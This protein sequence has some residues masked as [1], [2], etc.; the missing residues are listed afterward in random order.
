MFWFLHNF[1]FVGVSVGFERERVMLW[2]KFEVMREGLD[3][4][5]EKKR[6]ILKRESGKKG[7][8]RV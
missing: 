1:G 7:E 5:M 2:L 6:N 3:G 8:N 4:V